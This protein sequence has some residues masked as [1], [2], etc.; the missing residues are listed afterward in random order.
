MS[1]ADESDFTPEVQDES[2]FKP[3]SPVQSPIAPPPNA[4]PYSVQPESVSGFINRVTG[5]P[6]Y[7]AQQITPKSVALGAVQDAKTLGVGG[8]QSM[9][10]GISGKPLLGQP[11]STEQTI[12]AG[13]NVGTGMLLGGMESEGIAPTEGLNSVLNKVKTS[14]PTFSVIRS[15]AQE[16][17][18]QSIPVGKLPLP[19][20]D[21]YAGSRT[22]EMIP[23]QSTN[24][25][26][27]GYDPASK[28]MV[29]E[30]KN[31]KVFEYRGV[32]QQIFEK[33]QASESQGSFFANNIKGRYQTNLRGTV[34][35]TAGTKVKEALAGR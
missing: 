6:D 27:H 21:P 3:E 24:I 13:V 28:T 29:M 4:A 23:A 19:K 35:P 16:T 30:F 25:A 20:G 7:Q 5:H 2:D 8:L 26:K 14:D 34:K 10:K 17:P 33:Y 22:P 9:V 32:P 18:L 11:P 1:G 15:A 12:K 31:G